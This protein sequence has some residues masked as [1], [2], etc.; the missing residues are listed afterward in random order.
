M[1]RNLVETLIGADELIPP[2]GEI[3][4]TQSSINIE[5]L[6]GKFIYGAGGGKAE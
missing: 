4:I 5:G 1:G 6:I 3:K 2:G